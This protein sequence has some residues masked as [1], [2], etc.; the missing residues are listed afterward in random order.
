MTSKFLTVRLSAEEH[1]RLRRYAVKSGVTV[2]LLVRQLL[3][4][5]YAGGLQW[6]PAADPAQATKP[7]PNH[8]PAETA[9]NRRSRRNG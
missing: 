7:D 6:P 2:S 3:R 5:L 9:V 1:R 8:S 4:A